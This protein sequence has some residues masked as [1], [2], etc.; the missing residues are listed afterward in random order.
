VFTLILCLQESKT[1]SRKISEHL[2]KKKSRLLNKSVEI[3]I[4][5]KK[6]HSIQAL[7]IDTNMNTFSFFNDSTL[8]AIT[9]F[10]YQLDN[11]YLNTEFP[12]ETFNIFPENLTTLQST[13][14]QYL[15]NKTYL[16]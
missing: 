13:F 14:N 4:Y 1:H 11:S 15:L 5:I 6:E 9:N 7:S 10:E 8:A 16:K 2:S 3:E 12:D